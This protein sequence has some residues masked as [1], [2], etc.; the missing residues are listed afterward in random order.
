MFDFSNTETPEYKQHCMFVD[1]VTNK[2]KPIRDIDKTNFPYPIVD[3]LPQLR[4]FTKEQLLSRDECEYLVWLAETT[5]EWP[6][7]T[8]GFWSQ[9]NIGLL[10]AIPKH[11]YSSVATAKLVVSIHHKMKEFV[12]KSFDT[13]CYADQIGIVRWPPG[14][15]QMPHVDDVSGMSRVCGCVVYLND[16]YEGGIT[17]Y[18]YY[19]KENTPLTGKVF[20]HDSGN[21][22]LHGVTQIFKKTRYTIASTWSSDKNQS[23]YENEIKSLIGYINQCGQPESPYST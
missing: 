17:Y 4:V 21:A 12:S 5:L 15:Y 7:A 9:R 6:N 16:D 22:H 20:A 1:V 2:P 14:S 11:Q 18:P 3:E 13:E 8:F 23:N 19:G 10:T